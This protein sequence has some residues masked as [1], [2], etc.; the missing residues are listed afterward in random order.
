L[1]GREDYELIAKR[2]LECR[3]GFAALLIGG[4]IGELGNHIGVV[5]VPEDGHEDDLVP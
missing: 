1:V 2:A 4:E 3:A 5:E